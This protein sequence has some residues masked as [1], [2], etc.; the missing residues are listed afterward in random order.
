MNTNN[1]KKYAPQARREFMKAVSKRLNQFGIHA[2]SKG[3]PTI[4]T[5]VVSGSVMQ[6]EGL[7][8][9][10][11]LAR[12]RE[13]LVQRAEQ[14]GFEALVEQM[15]YTWFNR[16]SAIRY[17]ELHGYLEHNL[18]V[19]SHPEKAN[20]FEILDHT[21]DVASDLGL[22][23]NHIVELKLAGNKDEELYRTLLLGQC[24]QLHQAMPFLFEALDDETELLL[25]DNLTRTDSI[26]RGLVD[27]IPEDD[28]QPVEI[29]GWLY[30]FYIAEKKDQVIGKVV[31]SEDI[32]A[33]TQLFTPNW[34]VKYLVQ[35]SVG[36]QWLMTYPESG[37]KA[38]MAYYIEPAKQE[39]SVEEA[40]AAITPTSLEPET[41]KILD[42]ACGSGHILVEAYDLLK[43]IY[44]E[45]GYRL[46]DIPRLIL[47]KNI[48]GLDIDDR[49][50]Q[51]AGFALLMKA[52]ADDRRIL[53]N[54]PKL[55]ILALVESGEWQAPSNS[56][57]L[58]P[59]FDQLITLFKHAKTFGSLIQIPSDLAEQLPAL[60]AH[61]LEISQQ[62]DLLDQLDAMNL[63]PLV[64]QAHILAMKFDT[65]VAN[66]P[67]MGGSRLRPSGF[68]G[69]EARWRLTRA[70]HRR[71]Q[72]LSPRIGCHRAA[73][74]GARQSRASEWRV[75]FSVARPDRGAWFPHDGALDG[76]EC[77]GQ[78]RAIAGCR[79]SGAGLRAGGGVD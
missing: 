51:L 45:R 26:L 3:K 35:N 52:R 27:S 73:G 24:H 21:Q 55:N 25:P 39:A 68:S 48:Y 43:D 59:Y 72:N 32:P 5:P 9:D 31:K 1:L 37:L 30:Q 15:A 16:L 12:A 67:Y 65:V 76:D 75:P 11:G 22:D 36:R 40:L 56:K 33:A 20:S 41:L 14:V 46:R 79:L 23:R 13:R 17:M 61:L 10:A 64:A 66:P 53:E 74:G 44:L 4:S 69:S 57:A 62:G 8:F 58:A 70:H 6:I 34:I 7:S 63:L 49:A 71:A 2:D 19:L 47:E 60:E 38:Q 18:R 28:W 42:P 54:P 50:A 77:I 78:S 29:I